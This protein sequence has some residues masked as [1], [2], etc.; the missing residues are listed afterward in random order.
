MKKTAVFTARILFLLGLVFTGI[1]SSAQADSTTPTYKKFPTVPPLQLT[2][3]DSTSFSKEKLNKKKATMIMLFSPDCDHCKHETEELIKRMDEFRD[4]QII[5]ATP[6]PF[7]KMK[8]YYQ[9]YGL[10]K[11]PNIKMGQDAK[12][13]LPVFFNIKSFPFLAFY[14]KKQ[15]LISVFEGSMPMDQVLAELKK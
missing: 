11:Y 7:D 1:Q 9:H 8:E 4:V 5:M 6:L 14:N 13:M 2:L 15:E 3:V 12:F 10:A